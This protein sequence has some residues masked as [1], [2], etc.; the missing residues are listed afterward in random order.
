VDVDT[1]IRE[2]F[3]EFLRL[4]KEV[5]LDQLAV[6]PGKGREVALAVA[7]V[8]RH[9]GLCVLPKPRA[10]PVTVRAGGAKRRA[11]E[12]RQFRAMRQ[13]PVCERIRVHILTAEDAALA[14]DL[15]TGQY[16]ALIGV[17]VVAGSGVLMLCSLS[18]MRSG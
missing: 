5:V 3:P 7:E 18:Y 1:A 4:G 12:L 8:E 14:L 15:I 11:I 16:D 2:P 17:R 13:R 9:P 6:E 10:S